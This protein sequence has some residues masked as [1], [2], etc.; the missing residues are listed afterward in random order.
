[1]SRLPFGQRR[2]RD[3]GELGAALA[4]AR[5]RL[6]SAVV[7]MEET[8]RFVLMA[9]AERRLGGGSLA[10]ASPPPILL[11]AYHPA[12]APWYG[13]LLGKREVVLTFD[14]DVDF[15]RFLGVRTK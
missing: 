15:W 9:A 6:D 14:D 5:S 3:G 11:V 1:M 4:E 2:R 13:S 10:E 8:K 12:H 7:G